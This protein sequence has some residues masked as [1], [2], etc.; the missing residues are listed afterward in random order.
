LSSSNDPNYSTVCTKANWFNGQLDLSTFPR[1]QLIQRINKD[2]LNGTILHFPLVDA[3]VKLLNS[4]YPVREG[5]YKK[6]SSVV[7]LEFI[8]YQDMNCMLAK[9][10]EIGW[11]W[12][13]NIKGQ[14]NNWLSTFSSLT[15]EDVCNL[16]YQ[17]S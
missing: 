12:H 3:N 14:R 13:Y 10:L 4:W 16:S 11:K 1:W 8:L 9:Y 5:I 7:F 6:N 2:I 15:C 17:T